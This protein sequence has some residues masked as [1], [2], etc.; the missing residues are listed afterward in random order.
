VCVCFCV[1]V[2]ACVCTNDYFGPIFSEEL[3]SVPYSTKSNI[4]IYIMTM[5]N[6]K[7]YTPAAQWP[8]SNNSSGIISQKNTVKIQY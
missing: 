2:C 5:D 1:C 4:I 7:K 3:G 6:N 8:T